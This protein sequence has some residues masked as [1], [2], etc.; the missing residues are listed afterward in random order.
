MLWTDSVMW[1]LTMC[2]LSLCNFPKLAL[3]A[4]FLLLHRLAAYDFITLHK[5]TCHRDLPQLADNCDHNKLIPACKFYISEIKYCRI[6][7]PVDF[8]LCLRRSRVCPDTKRHAPVLV[9]DVRDM[10]RH[11]PLRRPTLSGLWT[12][13]GPQNR[14]FCP[15]SDMASPLIIMGPRWIAGCTI[16]GGVLQILS[17]YPIQGAQNISVSFHFSINGWGNLSIIYL[18]FFLNKIIFCWGHGMF[19]RVY[20]AKIA[21][22]RE[23]QKFR[24]KMSH[25]HY[26]GT[27]LCQLVSGGTQCCKCVLRILS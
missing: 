3:P 26:L 22:H 27:W 6:L 12:A 4:S 10:Q 2:Y 16:S 13:W 1:A 19:P 7:L 5:G 20:V 8:F 15:F 21:K 11:R 14:E 24:H 23:L 18:W 9:V 17:P 25:R